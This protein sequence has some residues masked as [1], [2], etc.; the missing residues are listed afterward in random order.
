MTQEPLWIPDA[1]RA[2]ESLLA[3][4]M[5]RAG[6]DHWEALH[7]WSIERRDEFWSLVWDFCEVRG[8]KGARILLEGDRMP[9]ARWFPDARLN[10]AENLLRDRGDEPGDAMVFWGEDRIRRRMSWKR[11]AYASHFADFVMSMIVIFERST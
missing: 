8:T 9:G 5:Q 4:F 6:H 11:C 3:R 10:F 1:D 2:A 7:R